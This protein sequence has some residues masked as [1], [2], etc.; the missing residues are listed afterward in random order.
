MDQTTMLPPAHGYGSWGE[1][2]MR[3]NSI[4]HPQLAE[5]SVYFFRPDADTLNPPLFLFCP[6][7]AAREPRHYLAIISFLVS[8]G[9]AVLYAPFKASVGFTDPQKAYKQMWTGFDTGLVAWRSEYDTSHVGIIGHSYGA[10][11]IPAFAWKIFIERKWGLQGAVMYM[12]APWYCHEITHKQLLSFPAYVKL[13]VQV[14]EHDNVNDPRIAKDIFHTIGIPSDEKDFI[15][16]HSD[17]THP[18]Y[19][20]TADHS[21]PNGARKHGKNVNFLDYNGIWRLLDAL[22]DYAFTGSSQAKSIALGNGNPDQR[23]MGL[24][25]E[26]D[27]LQPLYAGDRPPMPQPQAYYNNFWLNHVNP[28][29][30]SRELEFVSASAGAKEELTIRN[31]LRMHWFKKHVRSTKEENED[32]DKGGAEDSD[33]HG[34]ADPC[35]VALIDTGYGSNGPFTHLERL[36]P[37][38]GLGDANIHVVYPAEDEGPFPVVLFAPALW[39]PSTAFYRSLIDH[40]VSRGNILIFT[41]YNYSSIFDHE[42]RYR[43]M[44]LGFKNG[45]ELVINK[46]DTTRLALLGHSYGGGAVPA[47]GWEYAHNRGWGAKGLALFIMAPWYS[48]RVEQQQF[49]SFPAH[50]K[51]IVQSYKGDRRMDTRIAEDFFY[52]LNISPTEKDYITLA[53]AVSDGC[54][55]DA[56]HDAPQSQ[57]ADETNVVDFYGIW[58]PLDAL[59]DYAFTGSAAAKK[60]ALGNG[61]AA[62][63]F[64]GYWPD[65]TRVKSFIK[66]TDRP[67]SELRQGAFLFEWDSFMNPRKDQYH[68]DE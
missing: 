39:K 42:L 46:V 6:G 22:V 62:Q 50:A 40:I 9:N 45:L 65:G 10:G 67:E 33:Q 36:F 17:S 25:N 5:D 51:L 30:S 15:I 49:D 3:R 23:F 58:R 31:Y 2:D 64:C 1:Y 43:V 48:F 63:T 55:I 34:Q 14:F 37:H 26:T 12:M 27:S 52:S 66:V 24:W 13:I 47:I 44:L 41:T 68:P 32:T 57:D 59:M 54:E 29:L 18:D 20:L 8:N 28:R 56:D 4:A 60:V 35:R 19:I 38:P 21:T 7:I 11:A 53:D 61:G 16:L